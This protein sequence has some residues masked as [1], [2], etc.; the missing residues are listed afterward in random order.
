MCIAFAS[1][2]G[3]MFWRFVIGWVLSPTDFLYVIKLLHVGYLMVKNLF[4]FVLVLFYS[5]S[6]LASHFRYTGTNAE[7]YYIYAKINLNHIVNKKAFLLAYRSYKEHKKN[8]EILTIID[9]SK[10]STQKRFA[11]IDIK[12]LKLL[13]NTYVSHG[14]NSGNGK[15][16]ISFSN[17]INSHKSCLGTFL[18]MEQYFGKYGIA[19]RLNGLTKEINDNAK[20]RNIVIHGAKYSNPSVIKKI[21]FLGTSW[22]CPSIPTYLATEIIK[23]IKN[24]TIIFSYA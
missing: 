1:F 12:N 10:P 21:G 22:G 18:S 8:K 17:K 16:A 3:I 14:T 20:T 13:F 19:L 24:G 15:Y 9:Y 4:V 7:A 6:S 11:V 5:Q 23:T 2:F